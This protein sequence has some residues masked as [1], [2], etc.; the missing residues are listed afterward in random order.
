MAAEKRQS[1]ELTRLTEENGHLIKRNVLFEEE[2]RKL[3]EEINATIQKIDVN[4]LLKEIDIEDL[5]LI[6]QN[7]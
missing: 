3:N 1:Q 5:K 4:S 2:N 7:N 6:A